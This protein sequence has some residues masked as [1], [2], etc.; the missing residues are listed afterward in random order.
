MKLVFSLILAVSIST[1]AFAG[2]PGKDGLKVSTEKS[3]I[4][5]TGRKVTGKHFGTVNIKEGNLV[6]TDGILTAGSFK[7]DMSSIAVLDMKGES[8]GKLEGHLKS[9]DFFNV[10]EFPTADLVIKQ[11]FARGNDN[12]DIQADLTIRGITQPVSFTAFITPS[13]KHYVASATITID[14]SL[15]NVKYGSGRFFD[16][17]GDKTIYDEFDLAIQLVTE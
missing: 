16:S 8:A 1:A 17:L 15:Y 5:W 4:E 7:V 11:A 14:R 12:F 3:K 6:I 13:G 10:S 2:N 9:D